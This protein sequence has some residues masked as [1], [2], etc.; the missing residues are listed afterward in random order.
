[1]NPAADRGLTLARK[2][3]EQAGEDS[4]ATPSHVPLHDVRPDARLLEEERKLITHAIR[5]AAYNSESALARMIAPH[6]RR[7]EDEARALIREAITL[8]GDLRLVG[9]TLHI[10]LDPATAPRR[11]RAIAALCLELTA[12]ETTYPDTE[13]KIVYSVKDV[14][15]DT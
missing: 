4:R 7:A 1:M 3:L 14:P 11:S 13:L 10:T 12:T 8:S 2:R 5:M 9:D 15:G 6:Y